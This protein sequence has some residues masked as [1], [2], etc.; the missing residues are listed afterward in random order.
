[1]RLQPSERCDA[2][3][4]IAQGLDMIAQHLNEKQSSSSITRGN[5]CNADRALFDQPSS[6]GDMLDASL[7]PSRGFVVVRGLSTS[8]IREA[9]LHRAQT[10]PVR[11]SEPLRATT[12]GTGSHLMIGE[13]VFSSILWRHEILTPPENGDVH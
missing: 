10:T 7:L 9:Y 3:P 11:H 8:Q 12:E 5:E 1:M 6:C 4:H 13:R 2:L